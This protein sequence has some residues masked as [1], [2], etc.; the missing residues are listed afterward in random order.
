MSATF[1]GVEFTL[2]VPEWSTHRRSRRR[3]DRVIQIYWCGAPLEAEVWAFT[4]RYKH[5][6]VSLLPDG[7]LPCERCGEPTPPLDEGVFCVRCEPDLWGCGEEACERARQRLRGQA[8][9]QAED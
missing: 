6:G 2:S 9:P 5:Y 7:H 4:D 1:P 8:A 3:G